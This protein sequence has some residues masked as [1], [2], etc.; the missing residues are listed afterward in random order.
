MHFLI[1]EHY[2]SKETN[3]YERDISVTAIEMCQLNKKKI[4]IKKTLLKLHFLMQ[5]P[6]AVDAIHNVLRP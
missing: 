3:L 6:T 4:K 1:P 5:T 2:I